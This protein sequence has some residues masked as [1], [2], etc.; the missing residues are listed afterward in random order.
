MPSSFERTIAELLKPKLAS[1]N[2]ENVERLETM[3]DTITTSDNLNP[4]VTIPNDV[5]G[6]ARVGYSEARP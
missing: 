3:A 5:V 6:I 4:I 1:G 2:N